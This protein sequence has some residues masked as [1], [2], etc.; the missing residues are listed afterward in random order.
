MILYFHNHEQIKRPAKPTGETVFLLDYIED[1]EAKQTEKLE[2]LKFLAKSVNEAN[3]YVI[4]IHPF[5]VNSRQQAEESLNRVPYEIA[6]EEKSVM[7]AAKRIVALWGKLHYLQDRQA[8]Y[9]LDNEISRKMHAFQWITPFA[10][11]GLHE[12]ASSYDPA[13]HNAPVQY[14]RNLQPIFPQRQRKSAWEV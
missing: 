6:R 13:Y 4:F 2:K 12:A 1:D 14:R 7:Y 11:I 3:Y 10:P 9:L 8:D 5:K